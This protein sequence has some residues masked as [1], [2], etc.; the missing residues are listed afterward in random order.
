M[1]ELK[2]RTIDHL[3]IIAGIVD[4]IGLVEIVN[5]EIGDLAGV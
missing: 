5:A 4:Q 2:I 3:P 1:N